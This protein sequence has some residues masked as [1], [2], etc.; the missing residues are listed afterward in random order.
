MEKGPCSANSG[1]HTN[2][3]SDNQGHTRE[4]R[5][6]SDPHGDVLDIN[7]AYCALYGRPATACISHS[8]A[9]IFAEDARAAVEAQYHDVFTTLAGPMFY[10][11]RIQRPT[12]PSSSSRPG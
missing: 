12:V 6:I 1:Q 8:F 5:A 9:L 2:H 4:H 10:K 3:S 7:P 11:A